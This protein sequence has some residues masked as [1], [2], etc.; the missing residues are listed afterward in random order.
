MWYE[1]ACGIQCYGYK[2]G[3]QEFAK[4]LQLL[5]DSALSLAES[6]R[7]GK[8]FSIVPLCI[9]LRSSHGGFELS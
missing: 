5:K 9:H 6:E 4:I 2:R 1:L 3:C 8:D 7:N